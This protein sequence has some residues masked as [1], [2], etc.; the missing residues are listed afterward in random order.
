MSL[1]EATIA[2]FT[3]PANW[4]GPDGIPARMVEQIAI[5]GLS[6]LIA[7][8]IA[9]PIGLYVG[10]TRRGATLAVNLANIGRALPS[11]A[12]IGI[13]LPITAAIDPELGF[14]LYPLVIAMVVLAVPPI[15]VNTYTGISGVEPE[16]VEAARGLGHR[17]GQILR[18]VEIP[19]GLPVILAGL[20]TGAVQIVATA[21]LGAIFGLG[22]LGRFLVDG[23][24]QQDVGQTMGG[25]IL[26]AGLALAVDGLFALLQR[27]TTS[28][29]IRAQGPVGGATPAAA[30]APGVVSPGNAA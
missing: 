30:S 18:R 26:V 4:E 17:E 9:L 2:W 19:L 10:H 3:N 15:L 8:L 6:L 22:G 25:V 5:S 20:R 29:G 27:V 23:V 21:T 7:A 12:V 14:K 28:P 24:A 11:L 1:I 16:L 13:V